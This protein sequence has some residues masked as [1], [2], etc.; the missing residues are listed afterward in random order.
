[1]RSMAESMAGHDALA[2]FPSDTTGFM[3]VALLST[4]D[5]PSTF[6][7]L[8]FPPILRP[9]GGMRATERLLIDSPRMGQIE[10]E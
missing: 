5:I 2:F 6:R 9:L 1:M 10:P 8:F 3:L 7:F 4:V